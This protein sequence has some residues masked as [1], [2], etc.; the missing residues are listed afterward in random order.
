MQTLSDID[1][2]S[3]KRKSKRKIFLKMS[4]SIHTR[5]TSLSSSFIINIY[6]L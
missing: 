6:P 1:D 3:H 4:F 5:K 2:R